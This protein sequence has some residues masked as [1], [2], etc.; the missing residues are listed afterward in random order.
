[1]STNQNPTTAATERPVPPPSALSVPYWEGVA[2]GKLLLQCCGACGTLR[3][4]PRLLCNACYSTS[5]TWQEA[6]RKGTIHSWTVSHHAYHPSFAGDL[7]YTLV[8]VDLAEG[9][10][11]LGRWRGPVPS[12]GLPVVGN[13]EARPGGFGLVFIPTP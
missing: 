2:A 8:T 4:Y 6:S 10:R 12:I 5:V 11:A 13:F 9:P 3:H 7:P 1:M